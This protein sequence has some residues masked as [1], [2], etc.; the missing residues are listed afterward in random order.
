VVA[1]VPARRLEFV[2]ADWDTLASGSV[3]LD[4]SGGTFQVRLRWMPVA[5]SWHLTLS[6]TSG[7]V[8]VSGAAVRDRTDCLAGVS[9]QGRPRGAI[10]AYDP[11]GRGDPTLESFARL[12]VGLYY[13]PDGFSPGDF[14]LYTTAVA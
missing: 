3:V 8:V 13:L 14:T 4:P 7:A 5:E 6:L 10:V 2:R 12:G 9:T 11:R 1:L